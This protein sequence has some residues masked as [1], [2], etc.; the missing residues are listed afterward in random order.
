[1]LRTTSAR[2]VSSFSR[3]RLPPLARQHQ[4]E[5]HHPRVCPERRRS[6]GLVVL[7]ASETI[8]LVDSS[9]LLSLS[10]PTSTMAFFHLTAGEKH[11]LTLS[12]LAG[13]STTLGALI[14]IVRRPSAADLGFLLGIAGGVMGL[15][16]F[17]ELWLHNA[18]EHGFLPVTL[19]FGGGALAYALLAPLLPEVGT[20]RWGIGGGG[21]SKEKEVEGEGKE[22]LSASLSSPVGSKT[23]ASSRGG[24]GGDGAAGTSSKGSRSRDGGGDDDDD[25]CDDSSNKQTATTSSSASQQALDP[26]QLLRLGFVVSVAMTLH[27]LPEGFAVAFSS[28]TALG[29]VM[30]AAIAAH[31]IPE[32]VVVAAPVFAATGSRLAALGLAAA[33]GMSEPLG[34]AAALFL[35]RPW[36]QGV[37]SGSEAAEVEARLAIILALAGGIMAAVCVVDLYPQGIKCNA[38]RRLVLGTVL[39]AAAMA[40]TLAVG[41]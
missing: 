28:F 16:S 32:G 7:S 41:V 29:P 13:L 36:M 19:A 40:A 21:T 37:G 38:P 24:G 27:N 11:A 1:M 3:P 30:A 17:Y 15:L 34:A 6:A 8:A 23:T 5:R 33:S 20:E 31:N 4:R 22:K 10:T 9:P 26:A 18:L 39:G 12:T 35:A 14:A 2:T 25:D